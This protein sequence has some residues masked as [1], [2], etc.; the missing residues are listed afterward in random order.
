MLALQ[1][2]AELGHLWAVA[3]ERSQGFACCFV[4]DE[5]QDAEESFVANIADAAIFLLH[6]FEARGEIAP[7]ALDVGKDFLFFVNLQ[8]GDGG[9]ATNGVAAVG[10][11]A[12]KHV[13]LKMLGDGIGNNHGTKRKVAA[14]QAL[15]AS[16][17]IWTNAEM[18]Q[19][20]PFTG[21]AES[22]HDLVVYQ[23]DAVF[24][25]ER[26]ELRIV[27]VRRNEQPV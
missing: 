14:R 17:D 27:V 3:I 2:F 21:S 8:I 12:P 10:E 20:K 22:A 9:S 11:S 15:G 6:G 26:A 7:L 4:F 23:Q 19:S 5:F 13:R 25:A 16:H 18:L 24:V 1:V